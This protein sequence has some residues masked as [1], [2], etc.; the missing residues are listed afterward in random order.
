MIE[1]LPGEYTTHDT[2]A[3]AHEKVDKAKRYRQILLVMG[4]KDMTAKE[5]AVEMWHKGYIPNSERN[6]TAPRITELCQMGIL[7]PV[8]K[9]ICKYT[10]RKVTRYRHV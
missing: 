2:R 5:I 1:R 3:E 7:E 8:G 10:H 4:N 6:F 9:D